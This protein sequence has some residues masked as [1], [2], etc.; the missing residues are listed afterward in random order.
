VVEIL[1]EE[2]FLADYFVKVSD[3]KVYGF[4]VLRPLIDSLL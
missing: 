2:L 3:L 4:K 1:W